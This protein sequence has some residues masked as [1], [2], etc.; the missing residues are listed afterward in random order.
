MW[1]AIG[2]SLVAAVGAVSRYL[3]D[4]TVQHWHRSRWPAGTFPWG[5]LTIN[6]FGSL[7]LGLFAGLAAHHGLTSAGLAVLGTGF[8]G[9][10]TTFSTWMWE[11]VALAESGGSVKATINLVGSIAA[12]LTAA[13]VGLWLAN[14]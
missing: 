6:V 10:F 14:R 1:L 3:L 11:T 12:G 5:T 8:C 9:G 13:G 4:Q 7:L 2:V